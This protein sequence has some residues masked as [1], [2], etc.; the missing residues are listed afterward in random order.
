MLTN[1]GRNIYLILSGGLLAF[2]VYF[3]LVWKEKLG[4]HEVLLTEQYSYL[5]EYKFISYKA[6]IYIAIGCL[7]FSISFILR[8]IKEKHYLKFVGLGLLALNS[9]LFF[10]YLRLLF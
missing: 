4:T 10:H 5:S 7:I 6:V 3:F 2:P 1:K 9:F 8:L